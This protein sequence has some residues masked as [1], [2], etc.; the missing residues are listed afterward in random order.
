[1]E[2]KGKKILV[3]G[4]GKSGE[5][6]ARFL[7]KRGAKVTIT[8]N[9][10]TDDLNEISETLRSEGI[11]VELGEHRLESFYGSDLM[12]IS[13]GVPHKLQP[14]K[15]AFESG[16]PLIGEIEL[17]FQF[18]KEPIAAITGTNGKTTAVTILGEMF[19][20]SGKKV[21]VG[22]NIGT[23]LINYIDMDEKVDVVVLELSSFQLDT[24][25]NF[26]ANASAIIN[27]TDDHLDRYDDFQAYA[28]SKGRIYEN[29]TSD[30]VSVVNLD[31][32]GITKLSKVLKSRKYYINGDENEFGAQI[33]EDSIKFNTIETGVFEIKCKD[34]NIFGKH[35]YENIASA[36]LISASMG[37]TVDG[38]KKAV[39]NFKGL[40]HRIEFV[41]DIKGVKY[42]NDSKATNT[43]AVIRALESFTTPVILILGGRSK[44]SDFRI[45]RDSIEKHAK[46]VIVL[47]EAKDEIKRAIGDLAETTGV[48][49]LEKAV[50]MSGRMAVPGDIVLFSPACASFDMFNSYI[51][52]GEEFTKLVTG[53]LKR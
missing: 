40:P 39:M 50:V 19:R 53:S 9:R 44:N 32:S 42:F 27:I 38:I 47:G 3:I 4:L 45:L 51:H 48:E 14:V 41:K 11:N 8:D 49:T 21:F 36:A 7:N 5:G 25:K 37:A 16:V 15:L 12:V 26:R 10:T 31:D 18:I 6:C 24:I 28:R 46:K 33:N 22:G 35:N 1:M 2:I 29:Q 20:E 30:D 43:D 34:I 17:A 52:R 23:P 13:P